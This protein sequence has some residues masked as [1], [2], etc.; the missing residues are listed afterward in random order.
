MRHLFRMF[1]WIDARF[2]PNEPAARYRK[3]WTLGQDD[4]GNAIPYKS[5]S[6]YV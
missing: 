2:T 5:G 3:Q 4:F 1:Y 6:H